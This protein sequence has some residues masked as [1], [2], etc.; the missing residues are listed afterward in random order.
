VASPSGHEAAVHCR[1]TAHDKEVKIA[2]TFS[3]VNMVK[4]F[5]PQMQKIIG[6]GVDLLFS[7]VEEGM[8]FYETDDFATVV[9][10]MKG[11]CRSFAITRGADGVYLWDG[12]KEYDIP[13]HKV[14]A[15]DT[16]GAGDM[17]AGAFLY[18]LSQGW[19]FEKSGKLACRLSAEVVSSYG[20]RIE[21]KTAQ[22]ILKEGL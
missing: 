15:K 5:K 21:A 4:F 7:N 18:G 10:K 14:E 2:L 16:N 20:P 13:A 22:K 6:G 9:D 12:E 3:D 1:N 8:A 19:N 11:D 17:F